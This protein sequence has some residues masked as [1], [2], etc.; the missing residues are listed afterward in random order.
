MNSS[1]T[2]TSEPDDIYKILLQVEPRL[3]PAAI[4]RVPLMIS[5]GLG[6]R[7]TSFSPSLRRS[8]ERLSHVLSCL[9]SRLCV[10]REAKRAHSILLH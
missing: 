6:S 2:N 9:L 8:A 4:V 10:T 7:V 1:V 5:S 3:S